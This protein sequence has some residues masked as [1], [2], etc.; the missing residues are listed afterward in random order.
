MELCRKSLI[1]NMKI[2]LFG[3]GKSATS[4]IRYL[5]DITAARNWQLIVA[6]SNRPLAESKLGNASH[7]RVAALDVAQEEARD[8]LVATADI[9]ISLLPPTLHYLVALSCLKK[10]K[11]LLTASYLDPS[12][13]ALQADVMG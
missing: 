12:I 2:L 8:T 9:V 13:G 7:A 10:N 6:E 4:L 3:A 11:N 5:I 1:F